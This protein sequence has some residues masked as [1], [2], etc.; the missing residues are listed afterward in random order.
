MILMS[1]PPLTILWFFVLITTIAG[2][3]IPGGEAEVKS[4]YMQDSISAC[5][6][7]ETNQG[8]CY[9]TLMVFPPL[10]FFF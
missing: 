2:Q 10:F 9:F 8:L 5:L 3:G 1:F 4:H 7:Y 6:Y